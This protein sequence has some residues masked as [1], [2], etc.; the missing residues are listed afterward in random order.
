[1]FDKILK[2]LNKRVELGVGI[3]TKTI[4]ILE[5]TNEEYEAVKAEIGDQIESLTTTHMDI[6]NKIKDNN[7][8]IENFKKLLN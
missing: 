2:K 8:V 3:I 7:K 5:S 6:H 1:M 4:S